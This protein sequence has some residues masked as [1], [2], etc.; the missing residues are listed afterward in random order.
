MSNTIV[1]E[2]VKRNRARAKAWREANPERDR[3]NHK[4]YREANAERCRALEKAWRDANL[5]R[6]RARKKAYREA[7]RERCEA[8]E[9]A[10]RE[11]NPERVK[12]SYKANRHRRRSRERGAPGTH[13]V[14]QVL[15]LL[16]KQRGKC[17]YCKAGINRNYHVDHIVSLAMGGSNDILNLQLLCP[18]CNYRKHAKDPILFAQEQGLLL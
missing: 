13:T 11:A 17:P 12:A 1:T 14:Q 2:S 18:S 9:K 10:W 3:A 6:Y 5:E 8:T 4:A 7:N 16:Q 15:D